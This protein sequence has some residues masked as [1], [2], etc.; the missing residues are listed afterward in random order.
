MGALQGGET[1]RINDLMNTVREWHTA[2]I[3][4]FASSSH[5]SEFARGGTDGEM[6]N[7]GEEAHSGSMALAR[8]SHVAYEDE[9]RKAC[10]RLGYGF[11]LVSS[12]PRGL[13]HLP[14]WTSKFTRDLA[15]ISMPRGP[16]V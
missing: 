7:R 12:S 6:R 3:V 9:V 16:E 10:R 13:C 4:T 11:C 5:S 1:H 15:K 2:T 14:R 8:W